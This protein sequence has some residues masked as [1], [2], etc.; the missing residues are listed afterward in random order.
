MSEMC[1]IETSRMSTLLLKNIKRIYRVSSEKPLS[2]LIKDGIIQ[3]IAAYEDIL[4]IY[5]KSVLENTSILDC[6][7][8]IAIPGFVDSHTH[9]LFYGS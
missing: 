1:I 6:A 9:L 2:I 4:R 5:G 7:G 3:E 8:T